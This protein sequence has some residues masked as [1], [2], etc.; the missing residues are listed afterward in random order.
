MLDYYLKEHTC[1]VCKQLIK[2]DETPWYSVTLTGELQ[3]WHKECDSKRK[4]K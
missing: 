1:R 3:Q 2:D 4:N